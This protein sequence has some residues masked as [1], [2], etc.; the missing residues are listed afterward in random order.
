MH[1]IR[2]LSLIDLPKELQ[3]NISTYLRAF[4]LAA[5]QQT[6]RFFNDKNQIALIVQTFAEAVYPVEL[7]RGYETAPPLFGGASRK[8]RHSSSRLEEDNNSPPLGHLSYEKLRDMEML[9][10]VKIL[11]APEPLI[12]DDDDDVVLHPNN[13]YYVSKSWCKAALR[14]LESQEELRRTTTQQKKLSRQKQRARDRKLSEAMPPWPNANQDLM[15]PHGDLKHIRGNKAARAKRRLMDKHAWKVLK[16][17]YPKSVPFHCKRACAFDECLQCRMEEETDRK[18]LEMEKLKQEGDRKKPLN[19]PFI[20]GF[21]VRASRGFPQDR[22]TVHESDHTT[23]PL[24]PGTYHA[25]PRSWCQ[26]W[27]RYMKSGAEKQLSCLPPDAVEMLCDRHM[28]PLIPDHLIRFVQGVSAS[29][30]PSNVAAETSQINNNDVSP[31]AI[32]SATNGGVVDTGAAESMEW[33]VRV[34]AAADGVA[35][36]TGFN[37]GHELELQR[38]AL[39]N[40]RLLSPTNTASSSISKSQTLVEIVTEDEFAALEE[41]FWPEQAGTCFTI[42]FEVSPDESGVKTVNW[43][44]KPCR[45]CAGEEFKCSKRCFWLRNRSRINLSLNEFI[46]SEHP[47]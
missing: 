8:K 33:I 45:E 42:K 31:P 43:F 2:S 29:L 26:R 3:I 37:V 13:Y 23:T 15:C 6:C 4:D 30:F 18:S 12:P 47:W 24:L 36:G 27:R 46:E 17:L 14:W 1:S 38:A 22:T 34:A 10:L 40:I 44:T 9:V 32:A 39:A 20:R 28:M 35:I 5:L 21:Y 16:K 11:N 25:I 19:N 41:S 7:T